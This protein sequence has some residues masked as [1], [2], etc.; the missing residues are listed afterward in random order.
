MLADAKMKRF[1]T[2]FT[3]QWLRVREVGLMKANADLYPEYDAE[4]EA[5]MRGETEYFIAEMFRH[6]LPLV[7]L[8]DSDWAM[9]NQRLAKHYGIEGVMGQ[10]SVA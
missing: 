1:V 10:S 8:I 4:L 2:D 5:A 7:N 3:G 9:L 6:D